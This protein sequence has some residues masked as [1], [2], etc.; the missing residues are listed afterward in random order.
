MTNKSSEQ[1]NKVSERVPNESDQAVFEQRLA[2]AVDLHNEGLGGSTKAVWEAHRVFEKL[3]TDYPGQP[4]ADAFHGS[5]MSLIARDESNPMIRFQW[6][7][8]GLKLLDGAVASTPSDNRIRMLRGNIAYRL[9][10]QFFHRTETAIGDY[11]FLIDKEL[12]N[13]GS[14]PN[15]TYEKLIYELGEAYHRISRLQE[16]EFCWSRLLKQTADSKYQ[17]LI[18]QK[19]S[20]ANGESS[21]DS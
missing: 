13:P 6:V 11:L 3:R 17:H 10:E 16:A 8:R 18:K 19:M 7:R 1:V 2:A 21:N 14:I 9:P 15:H 12:R 20:T 5:I 4:I